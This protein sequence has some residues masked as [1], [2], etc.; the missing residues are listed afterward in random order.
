MIMNNFHHYSPALMS[1]GRAFS[2]WQ[3]TA[4]LNEQIRAREHIKTNWEYREYLQKNAN[5]IMSFDMTTSCRQTGCPY[6]SV[7]SELNTPSDLKQSYLSEQEFKK[8]EGS[9]LDFKL[10]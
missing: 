7:V 10:F 4:A 2:N 3:P 1:D 6:T 9:F 5:A 8:K